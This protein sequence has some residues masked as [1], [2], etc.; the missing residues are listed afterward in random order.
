M[1]GKFKHGPT[2]PEMRDWF[3]GNPRSEYDFFRE[4][5]DRMVAEHLGVKKEDMSTGTRQPNSPPPRREK[6]IN[7]D[8]RPAPKPRAPAVTIQENVITY[9]HS[10]EVMMPN[11]YYLANEDG[12]PVNIAPGYLDRNP[13]F[14][15]VDEALK[16]FV[17]VAETFKRL[18]P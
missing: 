3:E 5:L 15:S 14:K 12:Y 18:F 9:P 8:F 2:G 17:H 1:N 13:E 7:P 11:G 16:K 6:V 4:A 10:Y